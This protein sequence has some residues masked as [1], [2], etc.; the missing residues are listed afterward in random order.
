M[1]WYFILALFWACAALYI[2]GLVMGI[3]KYEHKETTIYYE[4]SAQQE[5]QDAPVHQQQL[6]QSYK[7]TKRVN[8][9]S[10]F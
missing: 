10:M 5:E 8:M 3:F 2:I 1:I 9:E 4:E 6:E 7:E